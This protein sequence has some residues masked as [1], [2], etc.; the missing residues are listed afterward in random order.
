MRR[1]YE[2]PQ[3]GRYQSVRTADPPSPKRQRVRWQLA[4]RVRDLFKGVKRACGAQRVEAV[5][6]L[7]TEPHVIVRCRRVAQCCERKERVS[8]VLRARFGLRRQRSGTL[9]KCVQG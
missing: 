6:I 8:R 4:R 9:D 1:V 7:S 5:R 2:T 3:A